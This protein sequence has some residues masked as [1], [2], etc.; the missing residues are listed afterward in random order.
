M[1]LMILWHQHLPVI[2]QDLKTLVDQCHQ[3]YRMVLAD[4]CPQMDL[5]VLEAQP[6]LRILADLCYPCHQGHH[7]LQMD[8]EIQLDQTVRVIR[9]DLADLCHL[10]FLK[11]LEFLYRQ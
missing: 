1:G 10:D 3:S 6:D 8:Q 9:Q 2:R 4:P 11:I 7:L 5:T